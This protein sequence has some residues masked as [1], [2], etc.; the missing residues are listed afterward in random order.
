MVSAF[1]GLTS[2]RSGVSSASCAASSRVTSPF[3]I[4]SM[5]SEAGIGNI[6]L[7]RTR[8]TYARMVAERTGSL[9]E[10]QEALGHRPASTTRV[11]VDSLPKKKDKHSRY[12]L[13]A[14]D[15]PEIEEAKPFYAPSRDEEDFA[16]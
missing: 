7:H 6:H 4:A 2:S 14:L 3:S 13:E 8:H 5:T 12:V 11:Y 9:S 10:T 1:F 15:L 16:A